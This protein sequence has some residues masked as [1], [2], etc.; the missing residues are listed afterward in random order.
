[1]QT[2]HLVPLTPALLV[3]AANAFVGFTEQGADN[4][5]Q[6]VERFLSQVHQPPGQPWCA[7]FVYHVG[8]HSHYADS[9]KISTWPL[10]A[11]ASCQELFA[12]ARARNVLRDEPEIGD[13][14]LKY[15]S[16]LRRYAHTGIITGVDN[17]DRAGI[18]DVHVC[19]TIEGNTNEDGSREGFA[20]LRKI[21]TFREVD[22]H[23]FIRWTE[24]QPMARAAA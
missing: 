16:E 2:P 9:T 15:S 14:F 11:T 12:Y 13:V 8:Y 1:M 5:G 21:R 24:I 19:T 17:P 20:T 3:A 6:V 23:K 22:G 18:R 10:P 7:A 4:H